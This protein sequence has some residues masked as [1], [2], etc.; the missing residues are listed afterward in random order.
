MSKKLRSYRSRLLEELLDPAE[1][2]S[3]VNAALNDSAEMFLEALKDV[4]QAHQVATVAKQAGVTREHLYRSLSLQGNPTWDTLNKVFK[5]LGLQ[6]ATTSKKAIRQQ[7]RKSA[8]T[9]YSYR[10]KQ[11]RTASESQMLLPFSPASPR[12]EINFNLVLSTPPETSQ[13]GSGR[14]DLGFA[15]N[16]DRTGISDFQAPESWVPPTSSGAN[17]MQPSV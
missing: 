17:Y 5:V 1:A 9:G 7:H 16:P 2:A 12:A 3:Y 6:F 14:P 8:K 13:P 10:A 15:I 11:Q 4:V